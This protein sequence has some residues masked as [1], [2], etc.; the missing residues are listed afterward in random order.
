LTLKL[1]ALNATG[2]VA[3]AGAVRDGAA[4]TASPEPGVGAGG[5]VLGVR[6]VVVAAAG[7]SGVG[8]AAI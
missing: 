1:S 6:A 7:A 5:A 3:A 4:A 2:V 8:A